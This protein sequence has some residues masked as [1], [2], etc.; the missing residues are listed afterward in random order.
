MMIV[1]GFPLLLIEFILGQKF[2]AGCVQVLMKFHPMLAGVGLAAATEGFIIGTYYIAIINWGL[3]YLFNTL[4]SGGLPWENCPVNSTTMQ[5]VQECM[6]SSPTE[7][8]FY[9]ETLNVSTELTNTGTIQWPMLAAFIMSWTIVFLA[10]SKGVES[11]GKV[12]YVTATFPYVVLTIFL[13]RGLTLDGAVDGLK[14]VVAVKTEYLLDFNLWIDAACQ[15]FYS[16]CIASGA[17]IAF[18]SYTPKTQDMM[19]DAIIVGFANIGSAMYIAAV[20]FSILGFKATNDYRDC[21]GSNIEYANDKYDIP[22]GEYTYKNYD[23]LVIEYPELAEYETNPEVRYCDF[24]DIIEN[25][26]QGT[27]LAF[28]VITEAIN[29]MPVPNLMSFLFFVMLLMLG[30]GSMF[31][32][33]QAFITPLFDFMDDLGVKITKPI[34]TFI[35]CGISCGIGFIFCLDTGYYWVNIFNDYAVN[36]PLLVIGMLEIIVCC[37]AYGIKNWMNLVKELNFEAEKTV[38][39]R[40]IFQFY[41]IML[42]FVSPLVILVVFITIIISTFTD[43]YEYDAWNEF[44]GKNER[45]PYNGLAMGVIILL[46]LIPLVTIPLFMVLYKLGLKNKLL[47]MSG[48]PLLKK[49]ELLNNFKQIIK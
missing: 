7:Y 16:L 20:I 38:I 35:A 48:E 5:P 2:Q 41:H 30:L 24:N 11:S 34:I 14:Y 29:Y 6:K 13:V 19:Y 49:K 36:L 45:K 42:R 40:I 47:K 3:Y 31:G 46:P 44:S 18:T 15:V 27:G 39:G 25:G 8:F 17:N 21:L 28:I 32:A 4:T 10:V 12:M 26:V 22:F 33:L 43:S 37:W 9:R 23:Q 1:L